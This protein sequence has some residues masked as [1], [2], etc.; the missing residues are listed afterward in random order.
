MTPVHRPLCEWTADVPAA[1]DGIADW[2]PWTPP[3][4]GDRWSDARQMPRFDSGWE[5]RLVRLRTPAGE[6]AV[7]GLAR[8]D[9]LVVELDDAAAP[10]RISPEALEVIDRYER[11]WPDVRPENGDSELLAG[12]SRVLTHALLD[13][14]SAEAG[15]GSVP[16]ALYHI[17]PWEDVTTVAREVTTALAYMEKGMASTAS[18][19]SLRHWFTPTGS[20][21]SAALDQL[22]AGVADGDPSLVRE[23]GTALC[24]RL[25]DAEPAR[26]PQ[27]AR[28]SLAEL[29]RMLAD[30]DPL[31]GFA[32]T[33]AADRLEREAR[34]DLPRLLVRSE[35]GLAAGRDEQREH[36]EQ[37]SA[38]R[39]RV[40]TAV[41]QG[42]M[43]SI[44]AEFELSPAQVRSALESY[45]TVI[46]RL[47][48]VDDQDVARLVLIPMSSYM[49]EFAGSVDLVAPGGIVSVLPEGPPIGTA[50]SWTLDPRDVGDSFRIADVETA[51]AWRALAS[52]L[53]AHHPV[54]QGLREAE[55]HG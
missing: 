19:T 3:N 32:A 47:R 48:L 8:K 25:L 51:A 43:L 49:N 13:R 26:F 55:G 30:R 7:L 6:Q 31:L 17:L 14:L 10:V 54:V 24:A 9:E 2:N 38:G 27:P 40:H 50:E 11:S 29:A 34:G 33:R 44:T 39:L 12:E 41:T 46:V 18:S 21:F 22:N 1:P 35:L 15:A 20:R 28:R 52:A 16:P 36:S 5:R 45:G 23:G 37:I 4:G 42:G 53:P